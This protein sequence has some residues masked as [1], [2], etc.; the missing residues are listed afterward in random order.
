MTD[1]LLFIYKK[2]NETSNIIGHL[3]DG[4]EWCIRINHKTSTG[5]SRTQRPSAYC[6]IPIIAFINSRGTFM[7]KGTTRATETTARMD[8]FARCILVLIKK[9][10]LLIEQYIRGSCCALSCCGYVFSLL[11]CVTYVSLSLDCLASKVNEGNLQI[12]TTH[13]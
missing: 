6:P 9:G 8:A 4:H 10:M 11:I 1:N 13:K 2:I 12:S 7:H 3:L 5:I